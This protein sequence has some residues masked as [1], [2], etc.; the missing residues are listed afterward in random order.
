VTTA[1][2]T[3]VGLPLD[4]FTYPS[5]VA[6]LVPPPAD[7]TAPSIGSLSLSPTSFRAANIG[8]SILASRVGT[9]VSDRLSEPATT[10]FTVQRVRAGRRSGRRCV[11]PSRANRGK[12]RCTRL[13]TISG[14]F[15]R[16]GIAGSNSFSF[17][18]RIGGKALGRGSYRLMA[19]AKDAAGNRSKAVT[20]AFSIVR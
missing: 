4:V 15:T 6:P 14:S 2:G 17:T 13:T 8:G 20:S 1:G 11:A 16:A 9:R 19:I 3:T 5:T 18:G 12:R 7:R 10:T